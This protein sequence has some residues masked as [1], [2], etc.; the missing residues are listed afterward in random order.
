M[1]KIPLIPKNNK[2]L[3]AYSKAVEEGGKINKS[4]EKEHANKCP[5][6]NK[7]RFKGGCTFCDGYHTFDELYEHRITLYIAL[8][9]QVNIPGEPPFDKQCWCATKHSDGTWW[10]DWF[11][12]GIGKE[13]GK[14]ITYHLPTK[15]WSEV[16]EFAKVLDKAPEFDGHT[17]EDVLERLSKL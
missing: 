5:R 15:Y 11:V 4:M 14:Q 8:C 1:K 6:H 3:K 13:K 7:K 2:H 10:D 9:K 12:L 17:S 16:C